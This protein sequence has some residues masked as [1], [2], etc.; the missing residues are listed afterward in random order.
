MGDCLGFYFL[1][2]YYYGDFEGGLLAESLHCCCEF[3][4]FGGVFGVGD[5]VPS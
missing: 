1:S 5:L 3:C 4:S 2:A